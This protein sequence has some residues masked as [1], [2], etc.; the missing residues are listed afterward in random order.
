VI[1]IV[2]PPRVIL[3]NRRGGEITPTYPE[4]AGLAGALAPHAAV[5]DGE[6]VAFNE[7]GQTS[8]QRLQR[9]MHVG[10]P[11]PRLLAETPVSLVVFD[12]LW[13]DGELLV[14][15]PQT[16]R[17]EILDRLE[18]KGPSWQTVPVLDAS[19]DELLVACRQLGLEGF[20]AKRRDAAYL[21]GARS[22]AWWKIKCGRR[23]EFVVG[24]WS[25][26]Q[27][28]RQ[29]SIGSLALGSYDV[30]ADEARSRG[31]PQQLFYVGQAGSGL[32]EEMIRQLTRLF[33]QIPRESSPFVN[34]PKLARHWVLPVLVAEIAYTEVTEAGTLRQP[35]IKG[36]RTDVI[37]NQVVFDDEF[38]GRFP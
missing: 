15:R 7:K 2:E 27:G 6:V 9:R 4:L 32:N 16:E 31:R 36:L 26:G 38:Q 11:D 14:E 34:P 33:A 29:A 24:G 17:R 35:S 21:V 22:P 1:A 23:R 12:V 18:I 19:P 13:L 20:M 30:T 3:T 8:F 5:L 28:T 10:G 25:S 37:A